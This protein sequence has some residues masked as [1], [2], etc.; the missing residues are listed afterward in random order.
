MYG[1]MDV[2]VAYLK[3]Q[4]IADVSYIPN[5]ERNIEMPP[6]VRFMLRGVG[7]LYGTK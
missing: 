1:D 3:E 7:M 4:G 6:A 2:F 5:T